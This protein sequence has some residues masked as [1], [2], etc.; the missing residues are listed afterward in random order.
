MPVKEDKHII[1]E[2]KEKEKVAAVPVAVDPSFIPSATGT[3]T[4]SLQDQRL[5]QSQSYS[6]I[7]SVPREEPDDI[8]EMLEVIQYEPL[9][10][11]VHS[12]LKNE[13]RKELKIK[14]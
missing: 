4:M 12:N 10:D 3:M 6:S 5:K 1:I 2:E 14:R 8:P 13:I 9:P 7:E 11:E